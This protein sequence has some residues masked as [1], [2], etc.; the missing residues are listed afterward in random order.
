M[1]RT[2]IATTAV[3]APIIVA[4]ALLGEPWL[5]LLV[6]V[7]AALALVELFALL[8]AGGFE[9]P[10]T[11]GVAAGMAVVAAGLLEA[12]DSALDGPLAGLLDA[13]GTPGPTILALAA[14]LLLFAVVTL[15]R[16]DPRTGFLAWSLSAFGV[17]YIGLLPAV[18]LVGHLHGPGR[19]L[20]DQV[21]AAG[22]G[23]GS[24]WT[25]LLLLLVWSY[26]TGAYLVGRWQGRRRLIEHVS[27]SKT[28]EGL[29]GGLVVATAAA[30]IGMVVVGIPL[31]HAVIIGPLVGLAAQA[32][33]LAESM[34]KR[35][36]GRKESGVL[37][38][39]HG[40]VLDR[41]DSFLF[42]APVLVAYAVIVTGMVV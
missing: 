27:P 28:V 24:A 22:L 20:S 33:D 12:N 25:L 31:W 15:R 19:S 29:V 10:R 30:A 13:G 14:A 41:I 9:P 3:V 35:A 21:G 42:A 34:I 8:S 39:G 2:R 38:P 37:F 40:G 6:A 5:S 36:A 1:L 32:G 18:A 26:D 4:I 7:L 17:A 23:S 16:S 11:L